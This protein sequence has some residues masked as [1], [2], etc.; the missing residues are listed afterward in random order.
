MAE[1][2]RE[3]L[4]PPYGLSLTG[5]AGPGGPPPT[6][7]SG[8][9]SSAVP[10]RTARSCDGTSSPATGPRSGTGAS[11]ARC[12]CCAA[13]PA[14]ERRRRVTSATAPPLDPSDASSWPATCRP[15]SPRPSA[16]GSSAELARHDELRV[17]SSLH[18]TLCFL[19]DVAERR[20][21]EIAAALGGLELPAL[22]TAI[23]EPFFL[24]QRGAKRVVALPPRRPRAA[25]AR[26]SGPSPT[27]CTLRVSTPRKR[28]WLASLT[29]ARFRRPGHPF[30]LQNVTIGAF[31]LPS[32]ILYASLLER[33]GAVH[34][35]LASFP[36]AA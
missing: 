6:S 16:A 24:P 27:P 20:V 30:P 13:A 26:P 12:T 25:L 15:T 29:V 18:V 28:P 9:S 33:A 8:W 23:G 32:V 36:T 34:T 17:A 7:R 5:V 31:G 1:G 2:V 14:R 21:D 3:R 22:P 10:D 35:P 11:S 4:G 19:G